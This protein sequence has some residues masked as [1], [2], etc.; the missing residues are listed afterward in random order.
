MC[1]VKLYD[2]LLTKMTKKI[3]Y[4]GK[5][6]D[7]IF[8]LSLQSSIS[9]LHS[10]KSDGQLPAVFSLCGTKIRSESINFISI[11]FCVVRIK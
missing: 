8:L 9:E 4:I 6:M 10:L 11:K 1:N 2:Y 3:K 7:Q 5:T